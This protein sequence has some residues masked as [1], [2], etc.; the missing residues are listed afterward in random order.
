MLQMWGHYILS[1]RSQSLRNVQLSLRR[2]GVKASG[3]HSSC[4]WRHLAEAFS[5][6]K[7]ISDRAAN[8]TRP[9]QPK[10]GWILRLQKIERES[11]SLW[12]ACQGHHIRKERPWTG[13]IS[14]TNAASRLQIWHLAYKTGVSFTNMQFSIY[15]QASRL[16]NWHL[17]L[18]LSQVSASIDNTM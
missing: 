1:K 10:Q 15:K 3:V 11:T 16:T 6:Q 9:Y 2:R 17:G 13:C 8:T 4:S 14:C 7:I 12:C 18:Q 5:S